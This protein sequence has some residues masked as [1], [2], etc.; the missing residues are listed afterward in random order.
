M[1]VDSSWRLQEALSLAL[2][3]R[4]GEMVGP[5]GKFKREETDKESACQ[6]LCPDIRDMGS[7]PGSGKMP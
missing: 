7:I 3:P 4:R 5:E 1:G 2:S 6:C